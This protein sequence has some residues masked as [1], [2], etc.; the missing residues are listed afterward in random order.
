LAIPLKED[1][2]SLS[3]HFG[4]APYFY[5]VTMREQEGLLLSEAFHGNS[6][7]GEKKGKGLKSAN[8][9]L[10]GEQIPSFFPKDLRVKE[11]ITFFQTPVWK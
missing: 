2:Q 11:P 7:A 9:C 6:F 1:K 4:E 8:G 5:L 3:E 10:K